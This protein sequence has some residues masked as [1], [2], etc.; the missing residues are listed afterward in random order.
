VRLRDPQTVVFQPNCPTLD[1]FSDAGLL[2]GGVTYV[3]SGG[4]GGSDNPHSV[5][6]RDDT[7]YAHT[8]GGLCLA[9]CTGDALEVSLRDSGGRV[10]FARTMERKLRGG[11]SR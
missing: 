3:I 10:L 5:T 7:V 6:W 2:P 1:D 4:G 11:G 8:D 9:R